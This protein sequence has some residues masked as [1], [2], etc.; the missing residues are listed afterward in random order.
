MN[1][2]PH[3]KE[4]DAWVLADGRYK[5]RCCGLRYSW[6]SV[7]ASVRLTGNTKHQLVEAFAR[8]L[9]V[10]QQ[11]NEAGAS[12]TSRE[13]F[14]RLLRA[15]CVKDEQLEWLAA[16]ALDG[17][18]VPRVYGRG[19][20]RGWNT[21]RRAL[22]LNVAAA[23]NGRISVAPLSRA[24]S[25]D[26]VELLRRYAPL[27][28]IYSVGEREGFASLKI[29]GER[30]V[31]PH[32]G[33]CRS[34]AFGPGTVEAFWHEARQYLLRIRTLPRNFFHL[35]LA[36]AIFRF[37]HRNDDLAAL[38]RKQLHTLEVKE[39]RGLLSRAAALRGAG[40]ASTVGTRPLSRAST[41]TA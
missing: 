3:C 13:R 28:G 15:C 41:L 18:A 4:N 30:V 40:S 32:D 36:E 8:Q 16:S 35:Y 39:V 29:E 20:M 38:L 24:D 23:R 37:N 7:W 2:C 6:T 11:R 31:V 33:G 17:V 1:H 12:P 5:C 25:I 21:A 10:Y 22:I 14:Y 26:A 19:G 27:G 34:A 9:P